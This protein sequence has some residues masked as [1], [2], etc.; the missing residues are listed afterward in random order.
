LSAN[1]VPSTSGALGTID[2]AGT[3]VAPSNTPI[4]GNTVTVTII[5]QADPAKTLAATV[6]L[7]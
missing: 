6:T 3:Y 4:S 5:S 1:G 2:S 7:Q